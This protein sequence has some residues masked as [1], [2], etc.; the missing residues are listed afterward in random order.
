MAGS[1]SRNDRSN[2]F[3]CRSPSRVRSHQPVDA[4]LHVGRGTCPYVGLPSP[5]ICAARS[6][7]ALAGSDFWP[8]GLRRNEAALASLLRYAFEQGLTDRPLAAAE[9]FEP[10]LLE[11]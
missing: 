6:S 5:G 7:V 8:Y 3:N 11:T 4:V 2:A 9:L 1:A 10:G